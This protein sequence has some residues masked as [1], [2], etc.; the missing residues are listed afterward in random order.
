[1]S[2]MFLEALIILALILINGFFALAEIAIVTARKTKLRQLANQG[3]RRAKVAMSLAENP[4]IFL[5]TVQVGITL[6]GILSGAIGGATL[7]EELALRFARVPWIAP[8]AETAGL[9]VVIAFILFLAVVIGELVPKQL[10]LSRPEHY[11][12]LV[13]MPMQL[14]SRLAAPIV[15]LLGGS[16]GIVVR[17]L[18]LAPAQENALTDEEIG[19]IVEE[20]V[21]SGAFVR[22][23]RELVERALRLD[24]RDIDTLMTPRVDVAWLDLYGT[25]DDIRA[26]LRDTPFMSYPVC[27]GTVDEVAGVV[28]AG[29]IYERLLRGEPALAPEIIQPPLVVHEGIRALKAVHILR[30]SGKHLGII[31]DEYG[32]MAGIFTATD[33][34]EALIGEMAVPGEEPDIVTRDDGSLLVDG[35]TQIEEI[36]ELLGEDVF[37]DDE[38]DS[39]NTIAGF[40]L[41]RLGEIPEIGDHVTWAGHYFEVVDKDGNRIDRVLIQQEK[42]D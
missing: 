31:V 9:F 25:D 3:K 28:Y 17:S 22:E 30:E 36:E 19:F 29:D 5:S 42:R 12:L 33:I 11:A 15:R 4:S 38:R 23:E 20:G 41:F 6:V 27:R 2:P 14:I 40:I 18:G 32:E 7:A 8:Y 24:D 34:L 10:A 13:A 26:A 1:M 39:Y 37:P 21:Q 35:S 16:S